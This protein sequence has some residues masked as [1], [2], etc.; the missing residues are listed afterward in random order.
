[1]SPCGT[2]EQTIEDR[3]TQPLNWKAEFRH[4]EVQTKIVVYRLEMARHGDA[5][6]RQVQLHPVEL[7]QHSTSKLTGSA[8]PGREDQI[9]EANRQLNKLG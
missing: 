8:Q 6:A 3:A 7:W 1:M 4:S 5:R 2:N 9:V